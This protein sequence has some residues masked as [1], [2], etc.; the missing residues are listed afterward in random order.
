MKLN[1]KCLIGFGI[2]NNHSF[3]QACMHASGAIIGSAFIKQ[4]EQNA[5][6]EGIELFIKFEITLFNDA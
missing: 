3:Q 2:S 4:L 1:N 6:K 5:T